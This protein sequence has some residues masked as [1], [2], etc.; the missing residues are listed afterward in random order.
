MFERLLHDL[1]QLEGTTVQ[2]HG[3]GEYPTKARTPVQHVAKYQNDGTDR[4]IKPARFVE[5]AARRHRGWQFPIFRAVG[6]ILFRNA[7]IEQALTDAGL[8]VSY[9]IN[10]MVNRIRTGRLKKSMRPRVKIG[11]AR[12]IK[13]IRFRHR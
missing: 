10:D 3:A 13:A 9:D 8:R 11:R 1:E 6:H 2:I 5:R 7:D 12:G 4:G